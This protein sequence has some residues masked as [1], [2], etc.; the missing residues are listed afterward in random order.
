MNIH[1]HHAFSDVVLVSMEHQR[2]LNNP[3]LY[4]Y[5]NDLNTKFQKEGK[6]KNKY[7]HTVTFNNMWIL[8]NK[9]LCVLLPCIHLSRPLRKQKLTSMGSNGHVYEF[10]LHWLVMH[11]VC[12]CYSRF[13]GCQLTMVENSQKCN[14]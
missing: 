14:C 13:T 3:A 5:S 10:C 8:L 11:F 6:Q 4:I 7:L 2:L 9:L 1:L 12:F